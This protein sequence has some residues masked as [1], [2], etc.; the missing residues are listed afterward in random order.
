[1]NFFYC[2]ARETFKKIYTYRGQT[3]VFVLIIT[4]AI[5]LIGGAALTMGSSVLKTAKHEKKRGQAYYVA[6][7]GVIR[8][9][10]KA[11]ADPDWVKKTDQGSLPEST[12]TLVFEN[13]VYPDSVQGGEIKS[14]IATKTTHDFY[15]DLVITSEGNY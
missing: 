10:D 6:E 14:V 9:I 7:A 13:V 11:L 15:Y 2:R 4:A 1:M 3:F 12:P 8:T 5:F